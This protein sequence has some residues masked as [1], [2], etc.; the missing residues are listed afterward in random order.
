[1][2]LR[3]GGTSPI[4]ESA[5]VICSSVPR[6]PL[7]IMERFKLMPKEKARALYKG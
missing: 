1:M 6:L 4:L 3:W 2:T 7:N 5:G